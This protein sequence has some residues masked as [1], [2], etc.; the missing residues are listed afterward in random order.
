[1]DAFGGP[2][3]HARMS[4]LNRR[5]LSGIV[6]AALAIP[7]AIGVA[8][9]AAARS[10][11]PTSNP[12]GTAVFALQPG[13]TPNYILPFYGAQYF[14][15]ANQS[16]FQ[17]LMYRPLYW[18]G[19][20][21][22]PI[23]NDS[24]SLAYP[25]TYSD[26]NTVVTIKMKGWKWSNGESVDARD[27][28]FWQNLVTG[29]KSVWAAYAP[30]G[31]PDNVKS[32]KMLSANTIQFTLSRSYNPS[33]FTY[34]E[35]SQIT[36]LP[37][38]WDV[39]S[40]G[41]KP[42]NYD[43]SSTGVKKVYT[44]LSAQ[45]GKLSTYATNPLWQ[46][47]D[48][49]WKL[50]TFTTTGYVAMVPNAKYSGSPKPTVAKFVEQPFTSDS[51]EFTDLLSSS[52]ITYGYVPQTDAPEISRVESAGYA[53]VPW[54][55]W[56]I[57]YF[58]YNFNNPTVGPVFKQ[59]YFRQAFQSLL[60][61]PQDI[62]AAYDNY[63]YPTYGP[64]PLKPA[65]PYVASVEQHNPYPY[66]VKNAKNLLTAHGWKLG[67]HGVDVCTKPGTASN[68][69]GPGVK[70][71]ASLSFNLQ[72]ASGYA[73]LSTEMAALKSSASLVGISLQL[74]Q[75]PANVVVSTAIPCA[76]SSSTC[77]WQLEDWGG[78]GWVYSPD[79]QPTG[80][81]LFQ[82]GAASNYGSY[83]SKTDDANILATEVESGTAAKAAFVKYQTYLEQ[84]LPVVYQV[85]PDYQIS[86]I[87][88][89]LAGAAPQD[90]ILNIYPEN[91]TLTK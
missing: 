80:D 79:Y 24:L 59:L 5:R 35:L 84:Q 11:G 28:L 82:T 45:A 31:Y 2:L 21:G 43:E 89:H 29:E 12:S 48:G 23:L 27:V 83:V 66:S 62:K 64:V 68:E 30:G 53:I 67:S 36:P 33:W 52:T 7:I 9:V 4:R 49:P 71:G 69:C 91:W 37:M 19:E 60:N 10:H 73:P 3:V 90:P 56:G 55:G 26:N 61:Q 18:F 57:N 81:E 42:G 34:N 78:L 41:G 44:Y 65:N 32:A 87:S 17:F 50:K 74:K 16:E 6:I 70:K 25:P 22:Q 54:I 72:Y 63:A 47:V 8:P 39:T 58:P 75:A 76:P 77:N 1:M 85:E 86:A 88:K 13:T 51:S 14:A 38:A 40:A 46:I 20:N 15:A